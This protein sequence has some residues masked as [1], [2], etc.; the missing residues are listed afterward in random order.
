MNELEKALME[1]INN[2]QS[3]ATTGYEMLNS[4]IPKKQTVEEYQKTAAEELRPFL[5]S[6]AAD[7]EYDQSQILFNLSKNLFDY[8]STGQFGPAASNF[9][10]NVGA[11]SK[12][13]IDAEKQR[14]LA[15]GTRAMA[16]RDADKKAEAD[17]KTKIA[18]MKASTKTPKLY[19]LVEQTPEGTFIQRDISTDP[20]AL[21]DLKAKF[22]DND[23]FSVQTVDASV[24][25]APAGSANKP[26]AV[27]VDGKQVGTYSTAAEAEEQRKDYPN[28]DFQVTTVGTL[29]TASAGSGP[30][31]YTVFDADNNQLIVT[32]NREEAI[33]I[34][35]DNPGSQLKFLSK[36]LETLSGDT[37][38]RVYE[39]VTFTVKNDVGQY[40]TR[41]ESILR[42][43]FPTFKNA[44]EKKYG[45]QATLPRIIS[46]SVARK[47]VT[48]VD[49]L[50]GI[51]TT[52]VSQA[53]Y[54]DVK[55]KF[56]DD[57]SIARSF[58]LNESSKAGTYAQQELDMLRA[59]AEKFAKKS[60]K[61]GDENP[62]IKR[63][64]N[65]LTANIGGGTLDGNGA[66]G[67]PN[68]PF[69]KTD[70]DYNVKPQDLNLLKTQIVNGTVPTG[71]LNSTTINA[72]MN[73]FPRNKPLR[74]LLDNERLERLGPAF[75][76]VSDGEKL[77]AQLEL[78]AKRLPDMI[79]SKYLEEIN[80]LTGISSPL[81]SVMTSLQGLFER[82]QTNP[83]AAALR[84]IFGF[85][86]ALSQVK[87]REIF[88]L[89]GQKLTAAIQDLGK[90]LNIGTGAF[91]GREEF[92]AKA[93]TVQAVIGA[94]IALSEDL[95][96]KAY[97]GTISSEQGVQARNSMLAMIPYR[98]T[99]IQIRDM[100][101]D[102]KDNDFKAALDEA[103]KPVIIYGD[104]FKALGTN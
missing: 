13:A 99:L 56:K 87:A 104:G 47:P 69:Y 66:L 2:R 43:N 80:T 61:T 4:L 9:I 48:A 62:Y 60:A 20:I 82:N 93:D 31:E 103:S 92:I 73:R 10:G 16:L 19:A 29:Q 65:I 59:K 58:V 28:Q 27:F 102:L 50:T 3:S 35:K 14:K 64:T 98:R 1:A 38:D 94:Q 53:A 15:I 84:Q 34:Q 90:T 6:R 51:K 42:K 68:L 100:A 22:K 75:A 95:V 57:P 25:V 78:D 54:D 89:Q 36:S 44:I 45:D 26:Y 46:D 49:P 52:F 101:I 88:G 97:A 18:S 41:T 17:I 71:N 5:G 76:Y 12:A 32:Q 77:R 30:D 67:L 7:R 39:N 81:T 83:E 21:Y 55:N 96:N 24:Q 74:T 63:H 85:T 23:N 86:D 37:E 70:S 33:K 72:L 91:V 11:I 40:E 8:G 79:N